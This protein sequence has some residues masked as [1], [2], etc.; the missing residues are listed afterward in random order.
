MLKVFFLG[1]LT[2]MANF[3]WIKPNQTKIYDPKKT[4]IQILELI[5]TDSLPA[6]SGGGRKK[7]LRS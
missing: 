6:A 1:H 4:L 3:F 5:T 2:Q 7:W